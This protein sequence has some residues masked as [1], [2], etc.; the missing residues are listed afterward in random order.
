MGKYKKVEELRKVGPIDYWVQL[1]PDAEYDSGHLA[2]KHNVDARTVRRWRSLGYRPVYVKKPGRKPV[3]HWLQRLP[4]SSF[5]RHLVD[6]VSGGCSIEMI[7]WKQLYDT[8]SR[9]LYT[10][11]V[12]LSDED[13]HVRLARLLSGYCRNALDYQACVASGLVAQQTHGIGF[14][15]PTRLLSDIMQ[16]VKCD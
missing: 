12:F 3:R 4:A 2:H 9:G 14:A 13:N 5:A 11:L 7:Q 1:E 16:V 6:L 8:H 10:A 15:E